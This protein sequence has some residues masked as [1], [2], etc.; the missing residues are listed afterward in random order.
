MGSAVERTDE[1]VR[2]YLIYRGFTSTL[3]HLDNEIKADK[4]KGLRVSCWTL[5]E[6]FVCLFLKSPFLSSM[7]LI[8]LR[9]LKK[10][11]KTVAFVF[12]SPGG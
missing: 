2:E 11:D 3:K 10:K 6:S 8:Y 9:R 7:T 1:H 4:E 5:P 12:A